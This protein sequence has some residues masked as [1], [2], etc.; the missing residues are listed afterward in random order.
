MF[1][2]LVDRTAHSLQALQAVIWYEQPESQLCPHP[3]VNVVILLT[4]L[5]MSTNTT[6]RVESS[7]NMVSSVIIQKDFDGLMV[8]GM[9]K[10]S[11]CRELLD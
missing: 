11:K 6:T 8:L 4:S 1:A 9:H 10:Q 2:R 7:K 5:R 3:A